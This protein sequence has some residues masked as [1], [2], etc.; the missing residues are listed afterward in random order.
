MNMKSG[1][2]LSDL[3]W[4]SLHPPPPEIIG[5]VFTF[6]LYMTGGWKFLLHCRWIEMSSFLYVVS[7]TDLHGNQWRPL[8][9]RM[10]DDP[11]LLR[12]ALPARR[13]AGVQQE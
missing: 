4:K 6:R 8:Q 3:V 2:T 7:N 10:W 5:Q 1:V 9:S 12:D 11:F 13:G